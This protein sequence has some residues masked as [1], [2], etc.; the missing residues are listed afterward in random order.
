MRKSEDFRFEHTFNVGYVNVFDEWTMLTFPQ[1]GISFNHRLPQ[2]Y[3]VHL[4]YHRTIQLWE[5]YFIAAPKA[6][7]G[8]FNTGF[9]SSLTVNSADR[10]WIHSTRLKIMDPSGN[11]LKN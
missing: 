3:K 5:N 7:P 1:Q 10:S 8:S 4:S 2:K 11:Q 9:K 6:Y